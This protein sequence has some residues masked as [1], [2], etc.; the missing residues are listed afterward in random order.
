VRLL[1]AAS[2]DARFLGTSGFPPC[3]YDD[4]ASLAPLLPEMVTAEM[5]VDHRL[6]EPCARCSFQ[7]R[8]LGVHKAYAES[9]GASGVVPIE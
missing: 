4:P 9:H 7:N 8:C 2:I 3:A 1:R 6:L 5:R